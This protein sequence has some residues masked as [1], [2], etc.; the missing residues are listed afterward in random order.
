MSEDFSKGLLSDDAEQKLKDAIAAAGLSPSGTPGVVETPSTPVVESIKPES[1]EGGE[2]HEDPM[3][4]TR[5]DEFKDPFSELGLKDDGPLMMT[6]P[7]AP[8]KA[9]VEVVP[10]PAGPEQDIQNKRARIDEIN[11]AVKNGT[12]SSFYGFSP[13]WEEMANFEVTKLENEIR[14]LEKGE[15]APTEAPVEKTP[16]PWVDISEPEPPTQYEDLPD[17]S[18]KAP[19]VNTPATEPWVDISEPEPPVHYEDIP[20]TP[21]KAP[22]VVQPVPEGP[23]DYSKQ[24]QAARDRL[25]AAGY[26]DADT[27]WK[28]KPIEGI[29]KLAETEKRLKETREFR[30]QIAKLEEQLRQM[31]ERLEREEITPETPVEVPPAPPVTPEVPPTERPIGPS[32]VNAALEEYRLE[33]LAELNRL[34]AKREG[35]EAA[36]GASLWERAKDKGPRVYSWLKERA[37]GLATFGYWEVRQAEKVRKAGTEVVDVMEAG[38]GAIRQEAFTDEDRELIKRRLRES[39]NDVENMSDEQLQITYDWLEGSIVG[40]KKEANQ[41]IEDR[42]VEESIKKIEDR[43]RGRMGTGGYRTFGG[44]AVLENGYLPEAKAEEIRAKLRGAI[45][46]LRT[47][48][49][50]RDI[51]NYGKLV[52]GSIDPKWYKRYVAGGVEAALGFALVNW[53]VMPAV[54]GWAKAKFAAGAVKEGVKQVVASP[55]N[56]LSLPTDVGIPP[57]AASELVGMTPGPEEVMAPL[58]DNLWSMG[59]GIL[60]QQGIAD[61]T[62]GQIME[63]TKQLA[64][65]NQTSVAK[66][67]LSASKWI[68]SMMPSG[69]PIHIGGA[70][71]VA[72]VAARVA[73]VM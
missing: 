3:G 59:K 45:G 29:S 49:I 58:K 71:R 18:S 9:P 10:S 65:D 25:K 64:L 6:E 26:L 4:G 73:G 7:E 28:N 16:E 40:E 38:T 37:K 24:A 21:P 66:W 15:T 70:L 1:G 14:E 60:Q 46:A 68:D 12:A 33:N 50:D 17:A 31:R 44:E 20:D 41:Q 48:Q 8:T 11:K 39:G 13:N 43:L 62:N 57:D 27:A 32:A 34:R 30:E 2:T 23:I 42:L 52:R 53:V 69:L 47:S 36:S 35:R 61:P 55:D 54:T 72:S 56:I 51:I 63:V 22:E 5:F 67:G 19:E